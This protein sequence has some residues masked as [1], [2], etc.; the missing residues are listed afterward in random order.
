MVG[1]IATRKHMTRLD[2]VDVFFSAVAWCR[3]M[4][5]VFVGNR[6]ALA[7]VVISGLPEIEASVLGVF[8]LSNVYMLLSNAEIR[9]QG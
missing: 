7:A 4:K 9:R 2:G 3:W 8:E 5:A 6:D 1:R